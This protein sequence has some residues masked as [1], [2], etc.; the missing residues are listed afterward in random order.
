MLPNIHILGI[1]G[2][3]KGTQSQLLIKSYGLLYL[4]S[5]QLFRERAR[6]D[7]ERGHEIDRMLRTGSL[8]PTSYLVE[9]VEN[10]LKS[11]AGCSGLL[12]DGVI[13]SVEQYEIF[14]PIWNSYGYGEPFLINLQLD[15]A[16]AIER[17]EHRRSELTKSPE[18]P[19]H[20]D[21]PEAIR[22]RF[23]LFREVTTPVIDTFQNNGRCVTIDAHGTIEQINA[24]IRDAIDATYPTLRS[25]I[26]LVSQNA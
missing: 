11:N 18:Q 13:R 15:E 3:G 16:T 25:S 22:E 21:D 1:Q 23:R 17:I 26:P 2:S 12:G 24:D 7:D 8:L 19:R 20:D 14:E 4:P 9:I 5:G 10:H 6:I